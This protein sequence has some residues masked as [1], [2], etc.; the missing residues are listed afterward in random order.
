[1]MHIK[2]A[3][4]LCTSMILFTACE[5][6]DS[7]AGSFE[8]STVQTS[9]ENLSNRIEEE[10]WLLEIPEWARE[11][12]KDDVFYAPSDFETIEVPYREVLTDL[13]IDAHPNH[14]VYQLT[15]PSGK[16]TVEVCYSNS[17]MIDIYLSNQ[18]EILYSTTRYGDTTRGDLLNRLPVE[19]I[20]EDILA[21]NFG[22]S[23]VNVET[24]VVQIIEF[25]EIPNEYAIQNRH[26]S[27]YINGIE[28]FRPEFAN[29]YRVNFDRNVI[30]YELRAR[31]HNFF[32]LYDINAQEWT[33]F[34][35]MPNGQHYERACMLWLDSAQL[36]FYAREPKSAGGQGKLFL[37]DLDTQ[38]TREYFSAASPDISWTMG[39]TYS[40]IMKTTLH[41]SANHMDSITLVHNIKT[42]EMLFVYPGTGHLLY[43][44]RY[45]VCQEDK[46]CSTISIYD[47][48]TKKRIVL[49]GF[50]ER[51][52]LSYGGSN[53]SNNYIYI[54]PD[55]VSW[56]HTYEVNY[57]VLER[58][59][60][61]R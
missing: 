50:E 61:E 35:R 4:V 9:E 23:Y 54:W 20:G 57:E 32:Y 25:P 17:A 8:S 21:V 19:W 44:N 33:E 49:T 56:A 55:G 28:H 40:D 59:V 43:P 6:K 13:E 10:Y 38:E 27:V 36:V 26:D 15:S 1:M 16:H 11:L 2:V 48:Q 46:Q 37:Y 30:A 3:V 14:A 51:V 24:G 39:A 58:Y 52:Q 45:W 29:G 18:D 60:K 31:E 53:L 41:T 12:L 42:N 34:Y 5:N 7:R 22:E 47:L